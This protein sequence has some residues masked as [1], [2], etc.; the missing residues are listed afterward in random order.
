M[1]VRRSRFGPIEVAYDDS[2]LAPRQWTL[3]QSRWAGALL[4]DLPEGRVLELCAGAGQIGLVV[5]VET[6]RALVQVDLDPRACTH[7]RTNAARAGVTT[8]VRCGD[9]Q[10]ALAADERFPLVLADP[11]YVP[12]DDV[13]A[14]PGDP[15]VAIDGGADGLDIARTCIGVAA[16]HLLDRGLILLQLASAE[17]ADDLRPVAADHGLEA[18]EVRTV[19]SSG[20]LVLLGWRR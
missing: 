17:Q 10:A 18:V 15:R 8:D 1:R 7:A 20:A 11:P 2:V 5:A 14:L 4:R 12:S 16:G 6:G 19:S 3:E 9:L 13:G